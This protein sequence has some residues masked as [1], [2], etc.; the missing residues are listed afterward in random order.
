MWK[1]DLSSGMLHGMSVQSISS[2]VLFSMLWW[3]L[4]STFENITYYKIDKCN[5]CGY[6]YNVCPAFW[7]QHQKSV[8]LIDLF[9]TFKA[10]RLYY[11]KSHL[12]ASVVSISALFLFWFSNNCNSPVGWSDRVSESQI[13]VI[14]DHAAMRITDYF[15]SRT[16]L[17]R[18]NLTK[19]TSVWCIVLKF[20]CYLLPKNSLI[21][22]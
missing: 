21:K 8:Y 19:P 1:V 18:S 11:N 22:I 20:V 16:F 6:E 2:V 13:S 7:C 12:R 14:L 4:F 5:V 17:V 9:R 10:D 15:A 3:I